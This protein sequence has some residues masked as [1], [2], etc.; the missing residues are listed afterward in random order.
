MSSG[1]VVFLLLVALWSGAIARWIGKRK[2]RERQ[3]LL[4]GLFLSLDPPTP[5]RVY[6]CL[7]RSA[8]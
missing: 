2:G 8:P 3:G 6:R 5:F 7:S 4:L 1:Q